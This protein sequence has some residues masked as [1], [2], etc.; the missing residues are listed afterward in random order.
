MQTPPEFVRQ[1]GTF[2]ASIELEGR[3]I[4]VSAELD[5]ESEETSLAFA[6]SVASSLATLE[7]NAKE[8][9]ARHLLE[10]YNSGWNEYDQVQSDGTI[11]SV[12][13]PTLT[14]N[15]FKEKLSLTSV[16]VTGNDCVEFWFEETK[17]FWGHSIIVTVFD[18][19]DWENADAALFG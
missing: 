3:S 11:V 16:K 1:D 18:E 12:C 19:L 4:A 2:Q 15:E 5:G 13:N 7:R 17:M 9:A 14:P 8:V 6:K 10:T